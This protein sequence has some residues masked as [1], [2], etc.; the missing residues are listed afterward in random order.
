MRNSLMRFAL[1]VAVLAGAT[2]ASA[3]LP[4]GSVTVPGVRTMA[5]TAVDSD[6]HSVLI[7]LY[8]DG[9]LYDTAWLPNN[10]TG[11]RTYAPFGPGP[12][13]LGGAH[14]AE[15]WAIDVNSAGS[16]TGASVKLLSTTFS[17]SCSEFKHAALAWCNGVTNYFRTRQLTTK[18][19]FNDH[20][21]AGVAAGNG[22]AI[23][24]L[25]DHTRSVNLLEEHGGAAM[26]LSIWGYAFDGAHVANGV[27]VVPCAP[28]GAAGP[29]NPLAAQGPNCSPQGVPVTRQWFL[30]PQDPRFG[31]R[32][33]LDNPYNFTKSSSYPATM[34]QE[35]RAVPGTEYI[36]LDVEFRNYNPHATNAHDQEFPA[37]HL[38][39]DF[40][41]TDWRYSTDSSP[42]GVHRTLVMGESLRLLGPGA[43]SFYEGQP[44]TV[45]DWNGEWVTACGNMK[46]NPQV[47]KCVTF[48][49]FDADI[50]MASVC[51]NCYVGASGMT[52]L[53]FFGLSYG[54]VI[55]A[56]VFVFPYSYSEAPLGVRVLD[57]INSLGSR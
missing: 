18:P 38:N 12:V 39:Y 14:L 24:Q 54:S 7:A 45:S 5:V 53:G 34:V 44:A 31:L 57:R 47:R 10:V 13:E 28:W 43:P 56:T 29:W 48:A 51:N 26:Q 2:E 4:T 30:N 22:G 40:N 52:P 3:A 41:W 1:G 19:I 36:Q 46:S 23:M 9:A 17:E 55:H 11:V 20:A 16:R 27:D 6:Y 42:D 50:S 37:L 21:W 33:E 32:T 49:T 8:I 25:Y 35:V 15:I